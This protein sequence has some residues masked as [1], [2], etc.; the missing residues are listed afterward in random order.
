VGRDESDDS[1]SR[2]WL[3]LNPGSDHPPRCIRLGTGR[4][5]ARDSRRGG[6]LPAGTGSQLT[7]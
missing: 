6:R 2:S 3:P 1:G 4:P 7:G 5:A